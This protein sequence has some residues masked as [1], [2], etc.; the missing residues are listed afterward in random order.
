MNIYTFSFT[1]ANALRRD[2]VLKFPWLL[3]SLNAFNS[4]KTIKIVII[5][6]RKQSPG[7][8]VAIR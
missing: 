2:R 4:T 7:I 3:A 8:V 5:D 1:L 6:L